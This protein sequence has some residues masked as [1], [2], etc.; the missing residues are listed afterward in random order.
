MHVIQ[1]WGTTQAALCAQ[2][3]RGL[4]NEVGCS[5]GS[6]RLVCGCQN[7]I[8][9]NDQD[10]GESRFTLL[11]PVS[12]MDECIYIYIYIW[13]SFFYQVHHIRMPILA[14]RSAHICEHV[15]HVLCIHC[16]LDRDKEPYTFFRSGLC[17]I[18]TTL[19]MLI[20]IRNTVE[21]KKHMRDAMQK[22]LVLQ[23]A[24]WS[25]NPLW[26]WKVGKLSRYFFQP[27]IHSYFWYIRLVLDE[28][29]LSYYIIAVDKMPLDTHDL[30]SYSPASEGCSALFHRSSS[31][32]ARL[33]T[34]YRVATFANKKTSSKKD[35]EE[36]R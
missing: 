24:P 22:F 29:S 3:G 1:L 7:G 6:L 33:A 23:R 9:D 32:D 27:I 2:V 34:V 16:P 11:E 25:S 14:C 30:L 8:G 35:S 36:S 17:Y 31:E 12:W 15:S 28:I 10:Q 18:N 26:N 20:Q 13:I 21:L 4:G 5:S 19:T